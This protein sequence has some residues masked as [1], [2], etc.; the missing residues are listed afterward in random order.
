[1]TYRVNKVAYEPAWTTSPAGFFVCDEHETIAC[2]DL[3]WLK[4]NNATN[5]LLLYNLEEN[6]NGER[7]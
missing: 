6:A 5:L 7:A 2:L 1:M 4:K 3:P